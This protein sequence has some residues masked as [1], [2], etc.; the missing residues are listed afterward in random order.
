[1]EF[2]EIDSITP[3]N[4]GKT[5]DLEVENDNHNFICNDICVSNSHSYSYSALSAI[6]VYLKFNYPQEFYLSL[7][8]MTRHEPDPIGEISKI[9]KEMQFFNIELL[10]PSLTVSE[11]DFS[12][13]GKN[14][15][16]G[17][18]SIKGISEKTIEKLNNFKR[19]F[20]NKFEVFESAKQAGLTIGVVSA[21]IQAGTLEQFGVNRVFLV[22]EAQ[23]WNVLTDKEK[24]L[25]MQ[26]AEKYEYKLPTL[27]LA[28]VKEIKDEKSRFLIKESRFGTIK[29]KME[30]YKEIY[31]KN[32]ECQDFA[33]WWYEKTLMGY[34][35]KVKL[36]NIFQQFSGSL[37]SI[38]EI[39]GELNETHCDFVGIVDDNPKLGVSKNKTKAN[40]NGS[41]YAVYSISDESGALK[42]M[43]FNNRLEQCKVQNGNLPK[44]GDIVIVKGQKKGEAIFAE[45]ISVQQNR[46]YTKLSELKEN[47]IDIS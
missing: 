30:R 26:Y 19:R 31:E 16:F 22:Y 8:K 15:R 38:N 33:N 9:H 23:L 11:L 20:A 40:P 36:I 17:L 24:K 29:K 3:L 28:M 37:S 14:I 39:Q 27:V 7:L 1:M 21:L 35:T 2:V 4:M 41:Q 47:T 10:A 12:I 34:S 45:S 43:I 32:K 44:A 25:A 13:E 42:T 46:I 6:S 18:S 5:I